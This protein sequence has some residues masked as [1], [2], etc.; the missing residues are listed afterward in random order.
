[1]PGGM[2]FGKRSCS[3]EG[4]GELARAG[5]RALHLPAC[6]PGWKPILLAMRSSFGCGARSWTA[7]GSWTDGPTAIGC[8]TDGRPSDPALPSPTPRC[9][10]TTPAASPAPGLQAG[11]VVSASGFT[12]DAPLSPSVRKAGGYYSGFGDALL[13]FPSAVLQP[14]CSLGAEPHWLVLAAGKS[15]FLEVFAAGTGSGGT[16]PPP[17]LG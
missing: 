5:R 2:I 3:L 11:G 10:C 14:V 17:F 8:W 12:P 9:G 13:F 6:R 4:K 16:I 7:I 1:M 15:R